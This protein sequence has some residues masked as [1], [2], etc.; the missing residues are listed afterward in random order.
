MKNGKKMSINGNN[1]IIRSERTSAKN[2]LLEFSIA[3]SQ[4]LLINLLLLVVQLIDTLKN[5][6]VGRN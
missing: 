2:V 1:S 3:N 4:L 5:V 6:P